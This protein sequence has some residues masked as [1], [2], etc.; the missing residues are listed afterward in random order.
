MNFFD[1]VKVG[2]PGKDFKFLVMMVETLLLL[3][4]KKRKKEWEIETKKIKRVERES[5]GVCVFLKEKN[6][7]IEVF[8]L[9]C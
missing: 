5:A 7:R 8:F 3:S 9:I 1:F 4:V 2:E 6:K